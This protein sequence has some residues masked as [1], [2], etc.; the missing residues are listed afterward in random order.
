[1]CGGGDITTRPQQK[2]KLGVS[3]LHLTRSRGRSGGTFNNFIGLLISAGGN[4]PKELP[5]A[6]ILRNIKQFYWPTHQPIKIF[7]W[8][9]HKKKDKIVSVF[10]KK[11]VQ[12]VPGT[13]LEEVIAVGELS[14]E[15]YGV[16]LLH[17][18]H[19]EEPEGTI[20]QHKSNDNSRV[21]ITD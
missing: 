8:L 13:Y 2:K 7:Y 17:S 5:C 18:H 19:Q 21:S 15:L 20:K 3:S 12:K 14:Q 16:L 1:M 10:K 6:Y 11:R 9:H 4:V